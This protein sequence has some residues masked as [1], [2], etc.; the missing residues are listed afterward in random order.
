[1]ESQTINVL[2]PRNRKFQAEVIAE[3]HN[4]VTFG[5]GIPSKIA[6]TSRQQGSLH[7]ERQLTHE[8]VTPTIQHYSNSSDI[9]KKG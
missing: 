8:S 6:N 1:M 2:H 5:N 9:T 7:L 3:S 4:P